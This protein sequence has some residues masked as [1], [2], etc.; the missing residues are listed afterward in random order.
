M[1]DPFGF[2]DTN[3]WTPAQSSAPIANNRVSFSNPHTLPNPSAP[4]ASTPST[5]S[6]AA[7]ANPSSS[8]NNNNNNNYP[9]VASAPP[10]TRPISASSATRPISGSASAP[11]YSGA[12]AA[13]TAMASS[14]APPPM[15]IPRNWSI[16]PAEST[17]T[18]HVSDPEKRGEGMSQ[19]IIYKCALTI[20]VGSSTHTHTVV[21]RRYSD[22]SWLHE[23]LSQKY[24][25]IIPPPVSLSSSFYSLSNF[26]S[27]DFFSLSFLFL[28]FFVSRL[29]NSSYS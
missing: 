4:P 21:T 27:M 8:N 11:V 12:A 16:F 28:F 6:S 18:I 1:D 2:G 20:M 10:E 19:Y 29:F 22:F 9:A 14:T 24:R 26:F 15:D 23:Q 25:G 5:T 17:F 7:A 3:N 13:Y